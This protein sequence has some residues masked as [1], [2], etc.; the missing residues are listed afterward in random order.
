MMPTDD[1][2]QRMMDTLSAG[3]DALAKG[4]WDEARLCFETA[5]QD[6]ETPE[7]LEG[8]GMAA[9]WLDD[10]ATIFNARERAYQLYRQN[11]PKQQWRPLSRLYLCQ[12]RCSYQQ[13]HH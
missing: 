4:A 13:S 12:R 2:E 8:L 7:A 6:E 9:W 1:A 3:G 10:A 11:A 5:L